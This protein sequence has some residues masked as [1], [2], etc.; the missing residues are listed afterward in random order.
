MIYNSSATHKSASRYAMRARIKVAQIR[1]ST[2]GLIKS[3]NFSA[4]ASTAFSAGNIL[5]G[6]YQEIRTGGGGWRTIMQPMAL[7]WDAIYK[8]LLKNLQHK[9]ELFG[10]LNTSEKPRKSV[11]FRYHYNGT[12]I[13]LWKL[14]DD[15]R[16][17]NSELQL[18]TLE[19]PF[20]LL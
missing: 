13:L 4:F 1:A 8:P 12:K 10:L 2:R 3:L 14:S 15:R 5:L 16:T 7:L 11:G 9:R 17:W 18:I 20:F 6:N 19:P